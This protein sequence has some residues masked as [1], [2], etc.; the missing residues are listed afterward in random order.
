MPDDRLV[1]RLAGMRAACAD[2][3]R[4]PATLE[5][6]VGVTVQADSE[7]EAGRPGA[8]AALL[9]QPDVIAEALWAYAALGVGHV[10]LDVQPATPT[11]FE[12][13]LAGIARF[14]AG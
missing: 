13:T 12:M 5:V 11:T 4:D 6:T 1:Q 3:G 2:A 7:Q 8:P 10:Q 9:G 14:R